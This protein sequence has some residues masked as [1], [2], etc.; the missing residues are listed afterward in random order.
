MSYPGH[1]AS[2]VDAHL[3]HFDALYT[4]D[5][6]PWGASQSREEAC[7]RRTVDYALG[8][9]IL[10]NGLEIGCGNGISTRA[11]ARRFLRLLAIDGSAH[12]V[13]LA[14]RQ[15]APG[16]RVGVIQR[17]LPCPLLSARFDAVV[18]SEVL[19]YLP[20]L[21]LQEML[22]VAHTALRRG[23]YFIS[24][25]HV[26]RF[27]DA[28][29]DHTTLVK[30]TR[31]VFGREWRQLNGYGWRCYVHIK[32]NRRLKHSRASSTEAGSSGPFVFRAT[33]W[34]MPARSPLGHAW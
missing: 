11:L 1:P 7:K 29:C 23:G 9:R 32:R 33:A 24:A 21:R 20:R 31:A 2:D 17:A 16:Q 26:R 15:V 19:Y 4:I 8:P 5:G 28:E 10:A 12:A 18:A 30:E 3:E 13:A 34:R 22:R 27:G 6:D 25:H 14:Q